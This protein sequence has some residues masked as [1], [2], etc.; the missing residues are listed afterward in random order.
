MAEPGEGGP[1]LL[2]LRAG[3]GGLAV[4]ASERHDVYAGG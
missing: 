2:E 1:R 3:S 4:M